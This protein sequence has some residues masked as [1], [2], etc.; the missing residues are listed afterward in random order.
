MKIKVKKEEILLSKFQNTIQKIEGFVTEAEGDL[1]VGTKYSATAVYR[2]MNDIKDA[3]YR[4]LRKFAESIELDSN[5]T[6]E[7]ENTKANTEQS[8]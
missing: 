4:D 5:I 7:D 8:I 1:S 3:F 2:R 6:R